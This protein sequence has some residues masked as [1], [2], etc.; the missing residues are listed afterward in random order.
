[1]RSKSHKVYS[2]AQVAKLL[3]RSRSTVYNYVIVGLIKVS[4]DARVGRAGRMVTEA[5]YLRLKRDGVDPTGVKDELAKRGVAGKTAKKK[6]VRRSASSSAA[7]KRVKRKAVAAVAKKQVKRG[8]APASG[9]AVKK[10]ARRGATVR[11]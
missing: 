9:K 1:M 2:L 5:E 11:R 4:P 6:Q 7:K 10:K 8:A 3:H